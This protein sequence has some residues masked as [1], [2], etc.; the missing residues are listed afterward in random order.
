MRLKW[1]LAWWLPLAVLGVGASLAAP[2]ASEEPAPAASADPLQSLR[3]RPGFTVDVVAQEPLVMDPVAFDWGPDGRLWVVEMADYPLGLD[4]Q[5]Q[6]GGRVRFL[7]DT[8]GDG[9]YDRSTLFQEGLPFPTGVMAWDDGVLVT[10]APE[11]LFL[12]DTDGDGRADEREVLYRGF[13]EGNQQHRANGFAWGLDN[14]IHVANGDSGGEI[15]SLKSGKIVGIHG[16]DV[17]IR[18]D[19]GDVEAQSGMSQFGRHRDD[20]GNWFGCNNSLPVRHYA[21]AD[22]YLRRNPHVR[23]PSVSNDIATTSNTQLFP[24][25]R[26]LSHF[27]GY[28]PPGPDEVHRFTSAC[29]TSVYRDDLFG[30]AFAH[31]TFTS[32]PV[33]NLVHR[34]N[35]VPS[36]TTFQSVRARDEQD[37][38]FL[39]STDSWFRP[40]MVKTG[41]DGAVWVA[42]M[43]RLVIEHPE[44]IDDALEQQI[45]LRAGHERGRIYRVYPHGATLRPVPHLA[46]MGSLALV[47]ALDH[48]NGWQRDT[49][50]QLLLRRGDAETI[51]PL[52]ELAKQG[53]LAVGRLHA[54]CTLEGLGGLTVDTLTV[55]FADEHPGV[56]R[57]AI[58]LAEPFLKDSPD[59]LQRLFQL[60]TD[61]DAHVRM[62]LAYTLGA[63]PQP[64]TGPVLCRL[65]IADDSDPYLRTAA[66]TSLSPSNL[67][68]AIAELSRHEAAASEAA[69]EGF[70][71]LLQLA[72]E[73]NDEEAIVLAVSMIGSAQAA[74]Q[75]PG[76]RF[77]T[78]SMLLSGL[79]SDVTP[80][81][82]VL[83]RVAAEIRTYR[84]QAAQQ[85][86]GETTAEAIRVA[87][88]RLLG[89]TP[90]WGD[91][92]DVDLLAELLTPTSGI[93]V[94][95][96]AVAALGTSKSPAAPAALLEALPQ[97]SPA[98]Q[99]AALEALMSRA[100]GPATVLEALEQDDRLG[101]HIGAVY[102][103]RLLKH[104]A[105]SVRRR[106]EALFGGY[107]SDRKSLIDQYKR[108]LED[109]GT[110]AVGELVFSQQCAACHRVSNMGH[111]VGPDLA[112][113]KDRSTDALLTAV[114]D[115]NRAVED[116][117][118]GY[119]VITM[120]GRI[121]SGLIADET[122]TTITLKTENGKQEVI[123]RN[124]IDE[125]SS[126]G[127]SLM[128]DGL[129]K[130]INPRQMSH[131]IAYLQNLRPPAKQFEGNQPQAVTA[132]ADEAIRLAA[133]AGWIYG[134]AIQFDLP[135]DCVGYWESAED[136]VEWLVEIPRDGTYE[137]SM[138]YSCA[139]DC[140]GARYQVQ[141][142]EQALEGEVHGT[143]S[144]ET[145]KT[146]R[147]GRMT[148]KAGAQH[149]AMR[150]AEE[151]ANYLLDLRALILKPVY[152]NS[153]G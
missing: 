31:S 87:A 100:G 5:G 67:A 64:Q 117:Y 47:A 97:L 27:V 72:A 147:L 34:R 84:A 99:S 140:A 136:F 14:W 82:P 151:P 69:R 94:Q 125:L 10:A 101:R 41:P 142:G 107:H 95:Q 25:S 63:L 42:D 114:L 50:Q 3:P 1:F 130:L 45:D 113:L 26:V 93:E 56:R 60:E 129:E 134:P 46:S 149:V 120:D 78:L 76:W 96:A 55:A 19:R 112:A 122:S 30:E 57:H 7:E 152:G 54:L 52:R 8:N 135:H 148:L 20:W 17:R 98:L 137:V 24:I 13:V 124:E 70:Q 33:H 73:M 40:T 145:F 58:R 85:A 146:V 51:A 132:G 128:P 36:G 53:S 116:K 91:E 80:Q 118:R 74:Q 11:I 138:E 109:Q 71:Q 92:S 38:E 90:G 143:G 139:D 44:W 89:Q 77:E 150:P 123:L 133:R 2:E 79:G 86:A 81:S 15:Q 108:G 28:Q 115:P 6:P 4:N 22:E 29:S 141:A 66:L 16:H 9:K 119:L 62:Q 153:G 121:L 68:A 144:W 104:P 105:E 43:Y 83:N 32:E 131:L 106:A 49:A 102:R 75:P 59:L 37:T 48:P 39:A 111:E 65:A 61:P 12:R 127:T 110:A 103:E 21:L 126:S 18:P 88:I 23:P 35:L